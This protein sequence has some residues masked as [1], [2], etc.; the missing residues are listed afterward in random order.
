M[1]DHHRRVLL[2]RRA[3]RGD[4]QALLEA[5]SVCRSSPIATS[6][7]PATSSCRRVHLRS[8]HADRHVETVLPIGAFRQRLVEAAMLGLRQPVGAE[9]EL[10]QRLRV[11]RR[12][13]Q[14][15]QREQQAA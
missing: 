6:S 2:E 1:R 8:A 14:A 13:G 4:R 12:S 11:Q 9:D 10:V 3:D 7:W 5:A 15:Q